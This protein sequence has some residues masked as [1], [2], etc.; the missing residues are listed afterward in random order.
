MPSDE[1]RVTVSAT[2]LTGYQV[3]YLRNP[4]TVVTFGGGLGECSYSYGN[5]TTVLSDS[6]PDASGFQIDLSGRQNQLGIALHKGDECAGI[7]IYR[8]TVG[9]ESVPATGRPAISGT[10]QVG[11]TLTAS[12]SGISDED[13]LDDV[14]FS[15][16]WT[17]VHGSTETSINGATSASY[18]ITK[19]D[20]DKTIKVRVTF[21]DDA[22]NQE[23]LSSAPTPAVTEAEAKSTDATLKVLTLSGVNFGT[24]ASSTTTYTARVSNTVSQTTVTPTLNDSDA[25]YIIKI[26]GGSD[27]DGVISLSV[28]SNVI[29]VEVTA[30]D[31]ETTKT[32]T[33]TVTRLNS[34][35]DPISTDATLSGLTLSGISFGTFVSETTSYTASVANSV[36]NTTVTPT[37]NHSGSSYVIKL[38]GVTDSDGAL[39]LAVGSNVITVEVTAEDTTT[40]KT[41]SV[42]V[43][44]A[45]PPSTDA[46]LKLLKINST[47]FRIH[48]L[49][50][51]TSHGVSFGYSVTEATITATTNHSAASYVIKV[52]GEVDDDGVV[53]L[54]QGSNPPITVVVTAEDGTTTKTY[55]V[56][57]FRQA[58]SND[59][60]LKALTL[61]G[62]SIGTF[63]WDTLSY[64]A[65][66]A[67]TVSQTAVTPTLNDSDASYVIKLGGVTDADGTVLLAV[68]S[69]VITVEVTAE[70][71]STTQTYTV[72][73]TRAASTTPEQP[74][75][76]ASLRSLTLSGVDFGTF[77]SGTTSYSA[78]VANIV[79]QTTV[80]P[81]VNDSDASHVIKLGGVTDTDGVIALSVGSNVITVEVTAEDTTTTTTYTVTVTRAAP[82]SSDATLK[83][84]SLGDDI[85]IGTF[86][87][88]T[89]SYS[90][91]VANSVTETTVTPTLNHSGASYVIKLG[92]VTD[93]DG[94]IPLGVGKNVITVEVTAEDGQATRTYTVTVTRA[95]PPS[96]DAT[97][98]GLVLS[99]V[100]FGT[101]SSA[102]TSYTAQV[103]NSVSQTTVSPTVND[104]GARYVIKL[105]S[106]TD[107][108]GVVS[109]AV[110]A[111][112]ITVEV[113]AE[114]DSTTNTYTVTVTRAEPP[115]TDAT[116]SALTLRDV[117][118]GTFDSTTTSYSA[119]VANSVLQTK[120]T[121][122]VNDSGARYVIKLGGVTA[123]DGTVPLAVD[124]NVITV[125]VTAE[126]DS[127]TQTYTVNVTRAEP[128]STD[129]TL[130]ALTL[131][132]VNFGTFLSA[133]TSYA[134]QVAN[135][136]TETI[137]TPTVN[138]S[139][140]SH[141]IKLDGVTDSDGTMSLAVGSNVITVEVTAEDDTTKRTYTVT[142]TRAAPPSSDASLKSLS[143]SG[144]SIGTFKSVTTTYS[145][146]VPNTL[147]ETTVT[148]GVN[149]S[150]AS[151]VIKLDGTVDSDGTVSLAVGKNVITVEVTAEDGQTTQ[152]YTINVTRAEPPSTNAR[153]SVLTLSGIDFGTF[154]TR[155]TSYSADVANSVSQT[156]VSPTANDSGA[157]YVIKL[158]GVIDSDGT[159][160][161]AVGAN[162]I[163]VE[164]TAEDDSTTRTYTVTVTRAE[165]DSPIQQSGDATLSALTLSGVNFGTFDSTTTSYT[166]TVA[167]SVTQTT[168]RPTVNDSGASYVIK[169]DGVIDSDGTVSLAVGSNIITAEVTA[170]DGE[171]TRTYT[172][173]VTRSA[174]PSTDTKLSALTLSGVNFGTFASGTTSYSASVSNGVTQ[175]TVGP[176]VNHSGAT[177]VIKLRGVTDADGTVSLSVGSNVITVEVTAQDGSTTRTYSVTITR[178]AP[179]STDATLSALSLSDV[180][181]GTFD[182]STVSYTADVANSVTETAVTATPNDSGSSFVIKLGGVTD[183]DGTVSLAVGAN[184]VTVEVT[185]QDGITRW[186]YSV[187]VTRASEN[188]QPP[189]SD[190][191][192]TGELPTDDPKVNFRVSGYAHDLVD[193][194]WAVPQSRSITEYVVQK[195]EHDGSEFVS[196]GNGEGSRFTGTT[197]D[198]NSHSLRNT[199]VEADTL[200]QYVLSL[201]DDSGTTII[202]SSTTVRTELISEVVENEKSQLR[203]R[204]YPPGI[205]NRR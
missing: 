57:L 76:D 53:S 91:Q 23:S 28:G 77:A 94:V 100:D 205:T 148:P 4:R 106:V 98:K 21:T 107:A 124:S 1:R 99:R 61:S 134:A 102:T 151:Y 182:S 199:D 121:P 64:T 144:T 84:L 89:T 96:T 48:P 41:Y 80:T 75:S 139:G 69:N 60:K 87:T 158:D 81:T 178:A 3:V 196:S 190:T 160:S 137:V 177:F 83:S 129:A 105:G 122:T 111:N 95:E 78:Q 131:S 14:S 159:V 197:N 115:S 22:G 153:L 113:T 9:V 191:P 141:V 29:T 16:Q 15:Y 108:D 54:V 52:D 123:S 12:T 103:V 47:V 172:V 50:G 133:T 70:D 163:T 10:A 140:A 38:D 165:P 5:S 17:R 119:Q 127:T 170:E 142:V 26:G 43:T 189:R 36:R 150:G 51:D 65:S 67:N 68:G 112:V 13:G 24:F 125:E 82:L 86:S 32:Y 147:S 181:F 93:S 145:V 173:T 120:V 31:G 171:S 184:V 45:D 117:D 40:T 46:T 174:P 130:S 19:A 7:T 188:E 72:T 34:Q 79:S 161:L 176:T 136:V 39:S 169:L 11:Q 194:A 201:N 63:A 156:T 62:L 167:N 157:T 135:S 109:L 42:T 90:V 88:V 202:E 166:A 85:S 152:T 126:D 149:Q 2:G 128:P 168:V 44:R 20:V 175:T 101:F 6:D 110:G 114:D 27:D 37:V 74:L 71:D 154:A 8:L 192:V 193:I 186:T 18:R 33:I 58:P 25:S 183:S 92:G 55:N 56:F 155:T 116:L 49:Q 66:V 187:T 164:V 179:V 59:A 73:V 97:L 180:N 195:Y 198:G 162:V 185:A 200:Y 35:S 203:E 30:E 143:L 204:A 138:D 146:Q 104:S 132:D 118:F